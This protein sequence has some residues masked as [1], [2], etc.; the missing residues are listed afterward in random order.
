MTKHTETYKLNWPEWCPFCE[1]VYN[2]R[3]HSVTKMTPWLAMYGLPR[4]NPFID[5]KNEE[6]KTEEAI[7]WQRSVQ[8]RNL[9]ENGRED[10]LKNIQKGQV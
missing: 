5:C 7:L 2:G 9:V 4:P 10:C 3:I 8:I 6:D 1:F